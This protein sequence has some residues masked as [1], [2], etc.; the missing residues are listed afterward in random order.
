MSR[1]DRSAERGSD[2]DDDSG[3]EDLEANKDV[4]STAAAAGW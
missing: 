2:D 1:G 3:G 4:S